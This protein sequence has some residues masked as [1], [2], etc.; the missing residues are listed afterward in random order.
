[1]ALNTKSEIVLGHGWMPDERQKLTSQVNEDTDTR[2]AGGY[3]L[4]DDYFVKTFKPT[5]KIINEN[6]L[7]F[8]ALSAIDEVWVLGHSL[9]EVDGIYFESIAA[10]VGDSAKWVVSYHD[11]RADAADRFAAL[12]LS[13]RLVEFARLAD[14]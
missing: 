5:D 13:V 8:N 6:S 4:I 7:F 10:N 9:S 11:D 1:M 14:L 12:G 3:E 2:V